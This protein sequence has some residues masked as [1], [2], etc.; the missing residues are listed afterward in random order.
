MPP[1]RDLERYASLGSRLDSQ[2]LDNRS[3]KNSPK[4][5]F[6]SAYPRADSVTALENDLYLL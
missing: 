4:G 6:D 5:P 3:P 1:T 2:L